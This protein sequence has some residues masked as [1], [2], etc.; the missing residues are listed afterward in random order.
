MSDT[1]QLFKQID[2]K[3]ADCLKLGPMEC[4]DYLLWSWKT[5]NR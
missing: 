1:I 2:P 4:A 5:I 3:C